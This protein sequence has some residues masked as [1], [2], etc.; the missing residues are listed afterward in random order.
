MT[1]GAVFEACVESLAET[2]EAA[3]RGADRVELCVDLAHDDCTPPLSLVAECTGAVGIPVIAM[4]RP[5]PGDFTYS[6]V[7]IEAMCA[8][9]RGLAARGASGFATGALDQGGEID[10]A[11]TER[12]VAAA[13]ELPVTFHRAFDQLGSIDEGL[14]RLVELGVR[15]V[16][17]SGGAA[18]AIEGVDALRRLAEQ[19]AGRIEV[20]AAG[21]I[22]PPNVESIVTRTRVPAVHARWAGW[23]VSQ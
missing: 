7:E 5:R 12:L 21:G 8:S 11:A 10:M 15:R 3:A 4:I 20:I 18:S 1:I 17:T 16:L 6:D 14:E 23:R 19:A 13:R 22:R 9:M 2:R